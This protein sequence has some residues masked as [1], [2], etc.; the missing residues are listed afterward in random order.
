YVYYDK[1]QIYNKVYNRETF[2]YK[3]DPFTIKNLQRFTAEGLQFPGALTSADIIPVFRYPLTIQE[4]FSLGFT[5]SSPEGGFPLYK[6][7]GRGV[8]T[9]KLSNRG[10]R[11]DGEVAYLDSKM[12]SE[13]FIFFPDSMN[14]NTRQFEI[15]Q[16]AG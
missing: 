14:S 10:F 4:D 5:T 7:K 16:I 1:P 15:P 9:F 2:F 13:N 8:G 12:F 3:I 11:E 6:D